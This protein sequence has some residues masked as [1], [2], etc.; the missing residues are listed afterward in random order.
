VAPQPDVP[1]A[2]PPW[3]AYDLPFLLGAVA[4]AFVFLESLF[5]VTLPRLR[6]MRTREAT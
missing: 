5:D 6:S 1:D 3:A 2:P 4:L